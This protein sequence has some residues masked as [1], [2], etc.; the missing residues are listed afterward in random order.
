[1]PL[2]DE[3][4]GDFGSD[5]EEDLPNVVRR[6]TLKNRDKSPGAALNY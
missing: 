5:T 3:D 4:E 6:S 2:D 1:L